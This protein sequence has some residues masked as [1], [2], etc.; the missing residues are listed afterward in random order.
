MK[1]NTK[2]QESLNLKKKSIK[3][4]T[5]AIA[6]IILK[7][8]LP[9]SEIINA[10]DEQLVLEA[11]KQDPDASNVSI[12][13][14]TG[15]NRRYIPGYL[16]GEPPRVKPDKMATILEDLRWTAHKYYNSN[17]IPKLGHFRTF[18]SICEQRASGMLTFQ[19]ILDEL[20]LLGNVKDLGRN[21]E[22]LDIKLGL[23]KHEIDFS[24]LTALQIN[25]TVDTLIFNS[26]KND[27]KD[28]LVQR[29]IYTTQ[30]N[31]QKYPQLHIELELLIDKYYQEITHK[32]IEFEDDVESGKYPQYGISFLEYK[33]EE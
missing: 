5:K 29:T 15:I 10:L 3:L 23:K 6:K 2:I 1:T 14:R 28:R 32:L 19:A 20:V 22:I 31:P 17:K 26:T 8:R 13:I 33:T 16:K 24:K 7:F 25:R 21:V 30:I 11:K 4:L 27:K 18:Q 9:R 12:A